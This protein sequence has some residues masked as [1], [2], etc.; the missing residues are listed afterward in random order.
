MHAKNV[1]VILSFHFYKKYVY[2]SL[3]NHVSCKS[4]LSRQ[5]N[6]HRNHLI[7]KTKKKE[8]KFVVVLRCH[9]KTDSSN[10]DGL[11]SKCIV[12]KGDCFFLSLPRFSFYNMTK[13]TQFARFFLSL[14]CDMRSKCLLL[15]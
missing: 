4:I 12:L 15:I 10:P 8:I 6:S 9:V 3:L 5:K 11:F 13:K 2:I 7:K 1:Y 14:V